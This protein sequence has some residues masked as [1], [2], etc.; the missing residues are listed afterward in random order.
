MKPIEQVARE[1][2]EGYYRVAE[3]RG[4]PEYTRA[5]FL[6]VHLHLVNQMT[7]DSGEKLSEEAKRLLAATSSL[8]D[9]FYPKFEELEIRQRGK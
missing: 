8:E 3:V 4:N 1:I 7:K 2:Y 6:D 5:L 9:E